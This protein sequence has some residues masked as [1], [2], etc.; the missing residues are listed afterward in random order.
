MNDSDLSLEVQI[1]ASLDPYDDSGLLTS[2]IASFDLRDDR[3]VEHELGMITGW[4]ALSAL[5]E[6][7]ADA[8]DAVSADS[9]EM[10]YVAS[11]ILESLADEEP[12][13]ED[14]VLINRISIATLFRGR[15]Y[16]PLMVSALVRTLRLHINGCIIVTD[17]EPQRPGGG[18]YE[19][20]AD[21][22]RA[23]A[24]LVRTLTDVG[25]ESWDGQKT[26]WM[27]VS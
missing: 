1:D 10:G 18:P 6:D 5:G 24:G 14:V 23:M 20:Q 8:A 16:L 15:G 19:K 26:L 12:F 3:G 9:A 2:F 25:F 4:F 21:R 22:D 27:H 17:P 13:L 11:K 7:L